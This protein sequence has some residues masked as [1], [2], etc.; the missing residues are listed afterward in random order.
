MPVTIF[1]GDTG[2][3][4]TFTV[5]APDRL[6]VIRP[7]NCSGYTNGNFYLRLWDGTTATPLTGG[8]W[9]VIDGPNGVVQYTPLAA[10]ITN[11]TAT[12]VTKSIYL[13]VY[14]QG[15]GA[16]PKTM[17]TDTITINPIH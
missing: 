12:A 15:P 6:G 8:T 17:Q 4:L 11:N 1:S 5:Q 2:S 10:E 9:V 3:P 7:I 13:T 16:G 14:T